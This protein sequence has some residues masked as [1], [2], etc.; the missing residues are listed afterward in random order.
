MRSRPGRPYHQ[1]QEAGVQTV[2]LDAIVRQQDPALSGRRTSRARRHRRSAVDQLD[3]RARARIRRPRGR[4]LERD[5]AGV[6]QDPHDTFV[7]APD[8]RPAATSMTV[9]TRP[10]A[11]G[12]GDPDEHRVRILEARQEVT[13]ADRQW[14][15]QYE[16]G[17]VVRYTTRQP[18][19]RLGAGEYARVAQ[20]DAR[21]IRSTVVN[22]TASGSVRSA[23]LA[24][25]HALSRDRARVRRG[26]RVQFTAPYRDRA[27]RTA[28]SARSNAS[29]ERRT[30]G[31]AGFRTGASPE[32]RASLHLDYGYAV[33]SHSSQGQTA[34]RVLVHVD[35]DARGRTRSIAAWRT[36]HCLARYD[37]RISYQ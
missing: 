29:H 17:D 2:R 32:P 25:R 15:E 6:R 20:I 10:A 27:S 9:S 16:R 33:T 1:L 14:A 21:T 7:V 13:G 28:N 22:A 12:P 5:R 24:G 3:N 11:R 4:R 34:N 35:T 31:S 19:A 26:D 30:R 8:N 37:A 23:T 36:S 18:R